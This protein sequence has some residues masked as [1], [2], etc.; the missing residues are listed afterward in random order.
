[1]GTPAERVNDADDRTL[2]G[3]YRRRTNARRSPHCVFL[4]GTVERRTLRTYPFHP[5]PGA[6]LSFT[7]LRPPSGVRL[8]ARRP[9]LVLWQMPPIGN[10]LNCPRRIEMR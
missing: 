5:L 1:M 7:A 9:S 10:A 2:R 3:R 6:S 4:P 8:T